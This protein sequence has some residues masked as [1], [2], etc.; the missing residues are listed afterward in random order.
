VETAS[1]GIWITMTQTF[2]RRWKEIGEVRNPLREDQKREDQK[3]EDHLTKRED[4]R[5]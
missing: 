1:R 2:N 4:C 5:K 3:E